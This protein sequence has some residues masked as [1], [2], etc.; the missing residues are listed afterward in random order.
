MNGA[1]ENRLPGL[2]SLTFPG[3]DADALIARLSELDLSTASACHTGIP[4]P[5]HVLRA[6]GLTSRDAYATLR[7][8]L[9]RG[10]TWEDVE[11]A[12]RR[13]AEAVGELRTF[14]RQSTL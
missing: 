14:P 12:T 4:E 5:S 9:G 3:V 1:R 11:Y 2:T 6:I 10:T 13:I 8:A 7:I